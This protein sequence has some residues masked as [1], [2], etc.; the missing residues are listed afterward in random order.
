M[1]KSFQLQQ[2]IVEQR[3]ESNQFVLE[4][5]FWWGSCS[6]H[7]LGW[8]MKRWFHHKKRWLR[9]RWRPLCHFAIWYGVAC[10]FCSTFLECWRFQQ[11]WIVEFWRWDRCRLVWMVLSF[12]SLRQL[13][14]GCCS[15]FQG[16]GW[17]WWRSW[18]LSSS[19][20]TYQQCGSWRKLAIWWFAYC[21]RSIEWW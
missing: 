13:Q 5:C 8:W 4:E 12:Q 6:W 19:L 16:K 15:C 3:W 1:S 18:S 2:S 11:C 14:H 10:R 7:Q 9:L 21:Y 20:S 17:R